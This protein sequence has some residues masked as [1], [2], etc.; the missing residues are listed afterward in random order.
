M[1]RVDKLMHLRLGPNIDA[2]GGLLENQDLRI[3]GQPFRQQP[4]L[5]VA[6]G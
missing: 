5:L 6:A 4:L 3:A 1:A 2:R